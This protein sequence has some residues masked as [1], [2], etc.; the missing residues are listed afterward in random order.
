MV[1]SFFHET[2]FEGRLLLV[3]FFVQDTGMGRD[4]DILARVLVKLPGS[5]Y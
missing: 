3:E 5:L 1:E 4:N 2:F